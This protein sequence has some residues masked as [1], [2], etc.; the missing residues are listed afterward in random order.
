M[1]RRELDAVSWI[2][3]AVANICFIVMIFAVYALIQSQDAIDE[4]VAQQQALTCYQNARM[5]AA[6]EASKK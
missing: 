3:K 4:A 5:C 2:A 6:V 1:T